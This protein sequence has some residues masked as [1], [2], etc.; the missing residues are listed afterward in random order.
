MDLFFISAGLNVIVKSNTSQF[1][2]RSKVRRHVSRFDL[3]TANVEAEWSTGMHYVPCNWLHH[4]VDLTRFGHILCAS[5]PP[6]FA[7]K[8]DPCF[9]ARAYPRKRLLT[10]TYDWERQNLIMRVA[11]ELFNVL[12]VL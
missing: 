8:K 1:S 11:R 6:M 7:L 9:S 3:S 4:P 5:K 2:R 12:L 10:R